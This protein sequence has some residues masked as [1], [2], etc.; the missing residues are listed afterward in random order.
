MVSLAAPELI[1]SLRTA[2]LTVP[3]NGLT[4]YAENPIVSTTPRCY[5]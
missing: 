1:Y 5:E 3:N 2:S 4:A